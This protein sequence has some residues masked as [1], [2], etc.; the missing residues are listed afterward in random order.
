M[1]VDGVDECGEQSLALAAVV[2]GAAAVEFFADQNCAQAKEAGEDEREERDDAG[3]GQYRLRR[4]I[5]A[6]RCAR[7]GGDRVCADGNQQCV[8][9][10]QTAETDRQIKVAV[11]EEFQ[12]GDEG[13]VGAV[14]AH[15][16]ES[17][18]TVSK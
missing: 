7:A 8:E 17:A 10:E 2:F 13:G 5:K 16:L 12:I 15:G 4:G 1:H 6:E 3:D 9:R 14:A 11:F 18:E